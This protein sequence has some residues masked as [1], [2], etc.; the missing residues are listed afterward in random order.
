MVASI[1]LTRACEKSCQFL[2]VF[3]RQ[4]YT[5]IKE[6][7]SKSWHERPF[8]KQPWSSRNPRIFTTLPLY[9]TF[10]LT[11]S[12][13]ENLTKIVLF[14]LRQTLASCTSLGVFRVFSSE[15]NVDWTKM[16][17]KYFMILDGEWCWRHTSRHINLLWV[18]ILSSCILLLLAPAPGF[19]S[20]RPTS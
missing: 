10:V 19:Q 4:A 20:G 7:T 9:W 17:Y 8:S 12:N 2:G 13:Y 14:F 3:E 16:K 15:K 5:P 11:N 1:L 18:W 6:F